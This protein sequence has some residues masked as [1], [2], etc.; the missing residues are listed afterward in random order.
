[1]IK[2][3]KQNHLQETHKQSVI[4]VTFREKLHARTLPHPNKQTVI[5]KKQSTSVCSAGVCSGFQLLHTVSLWVLLP[6]WERKKHHPPEVMARINFCAT[7]VAP[8][9]PSER[10]FMARFSQECFLR[11]TNTVY[12]GPMIPGNHGSAP[13]GKTSSETKGSS[14]F[15]WLVALAVDKKLSDSVLHH[16]CLSAENDF[17]V[18]WFSSFHS[19]PPSRHMYRN[20]WLQQPERNKVLRPPP[21]YSVILP[22]SETV[23][24]YTMSSLIST[25]S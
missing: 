20:L 2:M 8:E 24:F 13:K 18:S 3:Q 4:P 16:W 17:Q 12:T 15:T 9:N 6:V 1:M 19:Y 21:W 14:A 11:L 7:C 5:P 22:Y 23:S 25:E 10:N